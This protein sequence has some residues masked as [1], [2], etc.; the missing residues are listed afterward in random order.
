MKIKFI[1]ER[2]KIPLFG[3]EYTFEL[4]GAVNCPEYLIHKNLLI[5]MAKRHGLKMIEYER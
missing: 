2:E 4:E 3:A 5:K 1:C